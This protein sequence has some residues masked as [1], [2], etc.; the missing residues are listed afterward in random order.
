MSDAGTLELL[1]VDDEPDMVRGLRRIL[2]A[3]QRDIASMSLTV[4]KRPL[5]NRNRCSRTGC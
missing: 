1:V 4:V 3:V 5:R 2:R